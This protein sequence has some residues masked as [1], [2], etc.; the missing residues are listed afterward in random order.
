MRPV[1]NLGNMR[2]LKKVI[3]VT[4]YLEATIKSIKK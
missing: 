2:N 3:H 1:L 4:I